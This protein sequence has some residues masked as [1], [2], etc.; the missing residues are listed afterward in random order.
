MLA[1]ILASVF[2]Y[3]CVVSKQFCSLVS[4]NDCLAMTNWSSFM[5]KL[6]WSWRSWL[7]PL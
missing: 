5:E 3:I 4:D 2:V 6:Q 1:T 7:W